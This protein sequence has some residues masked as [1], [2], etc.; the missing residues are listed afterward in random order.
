MTPRFTIGDCA[1][2]HRA[3][4]RVKNRNVLCVPPD[5]FRP[6]ITSFQGNNNTDY[7]NAVCVDSTISDF[8]SLV[9]DHEVTSV[10]VLCN[11]SPLE[12]SVRRL[13]RPHHLSIS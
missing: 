3:D 5:N 8:W 7:I 2:G 12:A 6:Y 11:P 1:G 4:N 13:K 10:V 9:Y